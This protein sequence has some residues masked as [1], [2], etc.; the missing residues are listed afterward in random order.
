MKRPPLNVA[1]DPIELPDLITRYERA[2]TL[3]RKH[4]QRADRLLDVIR[5]TMKPGQNVQ[6]PGN[7]I[8]TLTDLYATSAKVFRAHGVSRYE[9]QITDL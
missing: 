7:R 3:G 9:L 6:L 8:A 5:K 1:P 2:R 4:Y